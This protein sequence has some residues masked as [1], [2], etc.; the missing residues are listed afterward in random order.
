MRI[1]RLRAQIEVEDMKGLGVVR[2]G[3]E[4]RRRDVMAGYRRGMDS[5]GSDS[6]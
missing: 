4:R 5:L 2:V 6:E 1:V 3:V